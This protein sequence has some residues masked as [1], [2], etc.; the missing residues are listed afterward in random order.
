MTRRLAPHIATALVLVA[1]TQGATAGTVSLEPGTDRMGSDYKGFPLDAADPQQCRA[2]CEQDD[3]CRAYTFVKPGLKGPQA[4]CFLKSAAVPATA[5]DCCTSG[6]K[7]TGGRPPP[8][9]RRAPVPAPEPKLIITAPNAVS[10]Q[11]AGNQVELRWTWTSQGC[12]PA[13]AGQVPPLPSQ[14]HDGSGLWHGRCAKGSC[15]PAS[16]SRWAVSD[17]MC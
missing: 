17:G 7:T 10:A 16:R 14:G 15:R 4:F 11:S 3:A 5:S 12:F 1:L 6:A 9:I 2:A 13:A 8:V